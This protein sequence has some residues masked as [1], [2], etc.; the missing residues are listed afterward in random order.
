MQS[1]T[2]F[3]RRRGGQPGNR[4][5]AGNRGNRFARGKRGNRGGG[6]PV[7]NQNARRRRRTPLEFLK[8]QYRHSAEAVEWL[9]RNA[10]QLVGDCFADDEQRDA[11]LYAAYCGLTPEALA[12]QGREFE[13]GL[14]TLMEE[15]SN[16]GTG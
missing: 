1:G 10:E 4:N 15:E 3:K 11:A 5:A 12:A 13:L 6:A 2:S 8:R 7:G 9:E 16:E 14:F